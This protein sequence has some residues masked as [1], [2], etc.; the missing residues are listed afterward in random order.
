MVQDGLIVRFTRSASL[1]ELVGG[2][3][4][5][6]DIGTRVVSAMIGFIMAGA[7]LK[8][9]L[10][11]GFFYGYAFVLVLLLAAVYL[12]L[13]GSKLFA[14]EQFFFK[15]EENSKSENITKF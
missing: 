14:V 7:I 5:I 13:I 4:L 2:M 12:V 3:A 8:V 11:A 6:L 9:N 15:D 1:F 10:A